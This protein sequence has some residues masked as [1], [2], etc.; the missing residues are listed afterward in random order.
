MKAAVL[1]TLMSAVLLTGC[2]TTKPCKVTPPPAPAIKPAV[3]APVVETPA[4]VAPAPAPVV[5]APA[6]APA[7]APD[8]KAL[9]AK[10]V[11]DVLFD[12]DKSTPRSES[13]VAL[14]EDITF[15]KANPNILFSLTA[16]CDV[17]GSDP[18]NDALAGRRLT[19]VVNAL[20][21]AGI[22]YSRFTA[23]SLGK[24]S[25]YCAVMPTKSYTPEALAAC[26]AVNRRV[27]FSFS[28]TK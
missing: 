12:F 22:D 4:P 8:Y 11:S 13:Q 3:V 17:I 9:F 20:T 6:P 26:R 7:P 15:L 28:G 24:T 21:A 25:A 10:N 14:S 16:S 18:Y 2:A 23:S 1:V 19:T 27:H 5:V